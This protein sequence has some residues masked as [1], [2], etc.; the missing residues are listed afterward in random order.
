MGNLSQINHLFEQHTNVSTTKCFGTEYD[1]SPTGK[2][3]K[4]KIEPIKIDHKAI[5]HTHRFH[6]ISQFENGRNPIQN[7]KTKANNIWIGFTSLNQ[8]LFQWYTPNIPQQ[9]VVR[10]C[11]PQ[12]W[13]TTRTTPKPSPHQP[14]FYPFSSTTVTRRLNVIHHL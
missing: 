7:K 11:S 10:K 3:K 4:I 6:I 5:V 14:H 12:R 8:M 2:S 13:S 9:F 1:V